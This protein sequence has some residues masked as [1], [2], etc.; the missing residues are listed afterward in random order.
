MVLS[1]I[2]MVQF[3]EDFDN[4]SQT[5]KSDFLDQAYIQQHPINFPGLGKQA[6]KHML[7]MDHAVVNAW[8]KQVGRVTTARNC[9]HAFFLQVNNCVYLAIGFRLTWFIQYGRWSFWTPSGTSR[10]YWTIRGMNCIW[11]SWVYHWNL[12]ACAAQILSSPCNIPAKHGACTSVNHWSSCWHFCSNICEWVLWWI[13]PSNVHS[14]Q[15]QIWLTTWPNAKLT[16]LFW[17][18]YHCCSLQFSHF[19][20]HFPCWNGPSVKIIYTKWPSSLN[21]Y[22]VSI[23]CLKIYDFELSFRFWKWN[24]IGS[25]CGDNDILDSGLSLVR[26]IRT[27]GNPFQNA[28]MVT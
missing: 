13:H 5:K 16:Y 22:D 8:K 15:S 1:K 24:V 23:T 28:L 2:D 19:P 12:L 7:D 26:L 27:W 20:T 21:Q 11:S 14:S 18:R 17:Q 6:W 3:A 10:P 9:L 25:Q 4:L